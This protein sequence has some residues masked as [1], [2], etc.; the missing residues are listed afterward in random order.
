[1]LFIGQSASHIRHKLQKVDGLGDMTISQLIEIA[2]NVYNNCDEA[3]K[4]EKLKEKKND[5]K[6]QAT[7]VAAIEENSMRGRGRNRGSY[8]RRALSQGMGRGSGP[9][10]YGLLGQNQCAYCKQEGHWKNEC[11]KIKGR[12][13]PVTQREPSSEAN[14]IMLEATDSG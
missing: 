3:E 14:L 11:P 1:M 8:C 6:L 12:Q 13:K 10:L 5:R 7:L 2:Y 9:V 4:R